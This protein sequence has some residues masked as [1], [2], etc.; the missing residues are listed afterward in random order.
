MQRTQSALNKVRWVKS[1]YYSSNRNA[2]VGVTAAYEEKCH[3]I[4]M[5]NI[6][7]NV[8]LIMCLNVFS[9]I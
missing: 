4:L 8:F 9:N 7:L 1:G 3:R 6:E 5:T 2:A